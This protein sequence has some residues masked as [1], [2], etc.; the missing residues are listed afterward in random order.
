M[1]KFL[2][3]KEFLCFHF[4]NGHIFCCNLSHNFSYLIGLMT[5]RYDMF[6]LDIQSFLQIIVFETNIS[7][8]SILVLVCRK[9]RTEPSLI[10]NI[11]CRTCRLYSYMIFAN[12]LNSIRNT[13][14]V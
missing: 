9:Q 7:F 1:L 13:L 2:K 14:I 10:L 3:I 6:F 8:S 5:M 4:F 12:F 11:A